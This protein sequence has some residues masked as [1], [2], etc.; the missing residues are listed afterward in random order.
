MQKA[1]CDEAGISGSSHSQF[2]TG[3]RRSNYLK[4]YVL[5]TC[6]I[7][8][9]PGHCNVFLTILR[10]KPSVPISRCV[11]K[12]P[13]GWNST[14]GPAQRGTRSAEGREDF[15][16]WSKG[17][18]APSADWPAHPARHSSSSHAA[19]YCLILLS[20]R[21]QTKAGNCKKFNIASRRNN[22]L[23]AGYQIS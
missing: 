13:H 14:W 8:L 6:S 19:Q 10:R 5:L 2:C 20:R 21:K 23:N 22:F 11:K 7:C 15:S 12:D 9:I 16:P 17:P 4:C 3:I 1:L 18:C